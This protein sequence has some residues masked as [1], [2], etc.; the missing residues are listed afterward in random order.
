MTSRS[1]SWLRDVARRR[2]LRCTQTRG[3]V[4]WLNANQVHAA[5][6]PAWRQ[7]RRRK[8]KTDCAW[9]VGTM[10]DPKKLAWIAICGGV[11]AIFAGAIAEVLSGS[12]AIAIGCAVLGGA[13]GGV[14]AFYFD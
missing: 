13:L 14:F 1:L 10:I 9:L 4:E 7:A 2:C 8:A 5:C 11:A 12:H 3:V 6:W